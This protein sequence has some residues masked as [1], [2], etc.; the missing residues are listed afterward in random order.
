[1]FLIGWNLKNLLVKLEGTMKYYFVG[2]MYK[3]CCTKLPYF[4]LIVQLI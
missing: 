4:V 2:V 3:K 1:L